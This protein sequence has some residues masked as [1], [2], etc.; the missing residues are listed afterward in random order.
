MIRIVAT[1]DG[2]GG[3]RRLD[4]SGHAGIGGERGDPAC[5]GVSV[6]ARTAARVVDGKRGF[7]VVGG[8]DG[9]GSLSFTVRR[10]IGGDG[11]WL[12]GVTATLITGLSDLAEEFPAG[13][14][15][16][17]DRKREREGR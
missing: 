9:P 6:L 11:R 14:T 13:V 12:R 3:L 7:V 15:V 4:V 16:T 10:R 17:V 8:H 2:R 1:V 5:A